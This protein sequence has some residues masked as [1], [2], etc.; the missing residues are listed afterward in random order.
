MRFLKL[1]ALA[2]A[3]SLAGC[4]SVQ[5]SFKDF[6]RNVTAAN[7]ATPEAQKAFVDALPGVLLVPESQLLLAQAQLCVG[8]YGT[9]A[10]PI[11]APGNSPVFPASNPSPA[12][13]ASPAPTK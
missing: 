7:C 9:Q 12:P 3:V 10:A 4:S 13:V 11:T 5:T 8:L 6:F 1:T 2:L